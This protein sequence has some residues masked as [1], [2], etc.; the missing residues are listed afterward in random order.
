MKTGW[1]VAS[2]VVVVPVALAQDAPLPT[3][4][5]IAAK[6]KNVSASD[7]SDSVLDGFYEVSVGSRVGYISVD[8]RDRKSVV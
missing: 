7:L 4:D 8:G 5:E 6:L 1:L 2:L 3:R